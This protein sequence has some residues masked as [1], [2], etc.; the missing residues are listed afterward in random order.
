MLRIAIIDD[1]INANFLQ[2]NRTIFNYR[3]ENGNVAFCKKGVSGCTH[4]TLCAR[5]FSKNTESDYEI[6]SIKALDHITRTCNVKDLIIALDWCLGSK[7]VASG[8]IV[9]N[10]FFRLE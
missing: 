7:S 9:K 5:I 8:C 1:G 2:K 4:G 3:I 6:V 10:C